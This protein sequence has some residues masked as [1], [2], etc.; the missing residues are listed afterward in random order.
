MG[1]TSLKAKA[2][3]VSFVRQSTQAWALDPLRFLVVQLR[4]Y[5]TAD[6]SGECL[7][8]IYVV[9]RSLELLS[10]STRGGIAS[11]SIGDRA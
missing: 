8:T 1:K 6:E 10:M 9:P 11:I 2:C 3:S 5:L 7:L 4:H